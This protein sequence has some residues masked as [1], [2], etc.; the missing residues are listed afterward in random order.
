MLILNIL[1]YQLIHSVACYSFVTIGHFLFTSSR[2]QDVG[3][4][5]PDH[6]S[7]ERANSRGQRLNDTGDHNISSEYLSDKQF[8]RSVNKRLPKF[9]NDKLDQLAWECSKSGIEA[10]KKGRS[11][12]HPQNVRCRRY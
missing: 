5:S 12:R 7:A 3:L 6:E 4:I 8:L 2:I 9:Y 10:E 1:V 11:V